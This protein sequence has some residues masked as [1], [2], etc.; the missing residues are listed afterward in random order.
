MERENKLK[1]M[2]AQPKSDKAAAIK[3]MQEKIAEERLRKYQIEQEL[4][5]MSDQKNK[6]YSGLWAIEGR[7]FSN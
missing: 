3:D 5:S 7:M 4:K 6:T 2:Y 1:L